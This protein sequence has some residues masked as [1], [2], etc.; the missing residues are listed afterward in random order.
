MATYV[1]IIV[2]VFTFM[3]IFVFWLAELSKAKTE[4][5]EDKVTGEAAPELA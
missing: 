5:I 2:T 1:T 3:C 4:I